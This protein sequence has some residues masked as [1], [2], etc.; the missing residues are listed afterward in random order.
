MKLVQALI[1][2]SKIVDGSEDN[3]VTTDPGEHGGI[4]FGTWFMSQYPWDRAGV[5]IKYNVRNVREC[6]LGVQICHKF[7]ADECKT[8]SEWLK[9]EGGKIYRKRS[10][11]IL[12]NI[13]SNENDLPVYYWAC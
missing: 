4:E 2:S 11:L 13:F 5:N 10:L 9:N 3:K 12:I 8:I 6:G 7:S 1:P